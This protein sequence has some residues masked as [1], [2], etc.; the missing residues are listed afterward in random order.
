MWLRVWQE[1]KA[2]AAAPYSLPS[3]HTSVLLTACPLLIISLML[4]IVILIILIMTLMIQSHICS[5]DRL[6]AD[7]QLDADHH[8]PDDDHVDHLFWIPDQD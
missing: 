4:I 6:R 3:N 5:L 2:L 1:L 8:D 7:H